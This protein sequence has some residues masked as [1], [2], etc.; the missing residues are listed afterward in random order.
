V[1][2]PIVLAS[3]PAGRVELIRG[4]RSRPALDVKF[5]PAHPA[6]DRHSDRWTSYI[7]WADKDDAHDRWHIGVTPDFVTRDELQHLPALQANSESAA[8]AWLE[9]LG[10]TWLRLVDDHA[11]T[12]SLPR[13]VYPGTHR[14][15]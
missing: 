10:Q 9:L 4:R 14:H 2:E 6:V 8:R 3:S 12:A 7:A 15:Q 1:A 5:V 13:V 11:S